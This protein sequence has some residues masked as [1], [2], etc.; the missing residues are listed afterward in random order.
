[1]PE[2]LVVIPPTIFS[3]RSIEQVPATRALLDGLRTT[4][5]VEVFCWP[6]MKAR[7]QGTA[8][9]EG[10]ARDMERLFAEPCH[11]VSFGGTAGLALVAV[12]RSECVKTFVLDGIFPP[13]ETLRRLGDR[14]AAEAAEVTIRSSRAGLSQYVRYLT[15]GATDG[16]RAEFVRLLNQEINWEQEHEHAE[17]YA[18]L[19]LTR[20][21]TKI[22]ARTLCLQLPIPIAGYDEEA[23]ILRRFA[24]ETRVEPLEPWGFNDAAAGDAL[25]RRILNFICEPGRSK[26]RVPPP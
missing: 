23:S 18:R 16:E 24:P 15:P 7:P 3:P 20:E 8:S 25:A 17:S 1:M 12:S 13:P 9:W 26:T 21:V 5:Q 10:E 2:R 22:S 19:D 14:S 6:Y 11:V 4:F